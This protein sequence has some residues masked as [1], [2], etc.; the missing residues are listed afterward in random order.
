MQGNCGQSW[1]GVAKLYEPMMKAGTIKIISQDS[2]T[3]HPHLNSL[4]VP[5]SIS[6]ATTEAQ[7]EAMRL[8]YAQTVFSRPYAVAKE[9]AAP[10]VAILRKAFMDTM[11]D[12]ELIKE[13]ERSS[14]EVEATDGDTLQKRLT[15]IYSAPAGAVETIR[16]IFAE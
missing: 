4:G 14:V 9:V 1:G 6:L 12:P 5:L 2:L 7:R 15:D 8:F 11:R 10:Q 13:A 16:K 3:G